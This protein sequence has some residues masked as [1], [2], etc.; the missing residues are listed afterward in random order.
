[1][2]KAGMSYDVFQGLRLLTQVDWL[3]SGSLMAGVAADYW[4]KDSVGVRAGYHLGSRTQG[5][6]SFATL[7]IGGRIKGL[8]LD[9]GWAFLG[10]N[11]QNTVFITISYAI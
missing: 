10:D 1:M 8:Q 11:H 2:L 9:A 6:A 7:G 5:T 4:W 3:V